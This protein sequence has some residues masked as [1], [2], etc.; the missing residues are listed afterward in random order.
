MHFLTPSFFDAIVPRAL[1][2]SARSWTYVSGVAELAV[3]AAVVNPATRRTGALAAA[4]LFVAVFPANIQGAMDAATGPEKAL[5]W[6]RLPFQ[7]P[8]IVWALRV[9]RRS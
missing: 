4:A 8:L 5:T 7:V 3:G 1:P 9:A 2:G 6:L